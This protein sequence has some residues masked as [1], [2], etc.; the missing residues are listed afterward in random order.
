MDTSIT[1][2]LGIVFLGL[3][4]R[5]FRSCSSCGAIP[6]T[7][8]PT[9][10]PHPSPWVTLHRVI[11]I[12]YVVIYIV[13]MWQMVP[14]MWNYQIEL[15]PRTVA[16]L[17]LGISIGVLL[18]IKISILR[19]FR[20]FSS[21][22]PFLGSAILLF[23]VLLIGLSVPFTLREHYLRAGA[24]LMSDESLQRVRTQLKTADMKGD[25]QLDQ[26]A[27][28]R[29]LREGRQVLLSKCVK[30]HDLRT[31]LLRPRTPKN[32]VRTVERMARMP[33]IGEPITEADEWTVS[34]YLIA[35]T[36]DL[37]NS[38]KIR[39]KRNL[40]ARVVQTAMQTAFVP[41]DQARDEMAYDPQ[42]A[43]VLFEETCSQC[44]ELSE[45]STRPQPQ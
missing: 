29:K 17:M 4:G 31:I 16:H 26:L 33:T 8:R 24:Q 23:T 35:I 30:C 40:E 5:L 19:F 42:V 20:H 34:A 43:R 22:L 27:S 25:V 18:L 39:R 28:R 41:H 15:P 37:Q 6:T 44:H 38:A 9:P 12:A 36:P 3:A 14:R 7:K 21:A 1:T 45:V 10:A 13:M 32:W 11:G 2:L